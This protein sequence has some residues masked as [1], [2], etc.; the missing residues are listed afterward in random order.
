MPFM[1]S[2]T[3]DETE[4]QT[5]DVVGRAIDTHLQAFERTVVMLT[6]LLLPAYKVLINHSRP[7]PIVPL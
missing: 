4:L 2:A 3:V 7:N 6:K 5:A 1:D